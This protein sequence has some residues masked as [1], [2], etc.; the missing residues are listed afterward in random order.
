MNISEKIKKYLGE[1][2][3]PSKK[4]DIMNQ[5][6]DKQSQDMFGRPRTQSI[7][8]NVCVSCGKPA[9]KFK[10]QLSKKEYTISGFCQKCQDATF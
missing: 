10:D 5:F 2:A 8:S 7:V 9:T 4:S 6:L 1:M 3:E